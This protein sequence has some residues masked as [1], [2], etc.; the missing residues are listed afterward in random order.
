[1]WELI[2]GWP[3]V[4]LRRW[5]LIVA[6]GIGFLLAGIAVWLATGDRVLLMLSVT[7][8]ALSL[9][10]AG[11]LFRRISLGDYVILTGVCVQISSL[12]LQK[13]RKV[14]LLDQDEQEICLLVGKQ[15]H[16]R[17][18]TWYRFYLQQASAGIPS[19]WLPSSLAA[20]NLLGV[21]ELAEDW[22]NHGDPCKK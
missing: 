5:L 7:M 2:R 12:T 1:M 11:L 18:G 21:E 8:F 10:R 19:A 20:G 4:L 14:R 16:L 6:A 15:Y 3:P 9:G 22:E 17:P 13:C